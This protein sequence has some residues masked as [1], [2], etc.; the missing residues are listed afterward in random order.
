MISQHSQT[1]TVQV[2]VS[3]QEAIA[4][5]QDFIDMRPDAREARKALAVKLIYQGYLYDEIQTFFFDF[6]RVTSLV[7]I[8]VY[9]LATTVYTNIVL[10]PFFMTIFIYMS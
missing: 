2:K 7:F 3:Q 4:E 5:L 9:K 8:R 1:A 6:F 10:F